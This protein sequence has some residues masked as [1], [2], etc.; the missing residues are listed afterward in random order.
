MLS[1]Y[2]H[3]RTYPATDLICSPLVRKQ[4]SPQVLDHLKGGLTRLTLN[5][6]FKDKIHQADSRQRR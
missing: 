6:I 5:C 4:A 1:L 3:Q 2:L